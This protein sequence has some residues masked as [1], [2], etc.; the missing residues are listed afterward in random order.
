M[1]M[2]LMSGLGMISETRGNVLNGDGEGE[3]WNMKKRNPG[4]VVG[5]GLPDIGKACTNPSGYVKPLLFYYYS[6]YFVLPLVGS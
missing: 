1:W 2:L 6:Y 4:G 3:V 5:I